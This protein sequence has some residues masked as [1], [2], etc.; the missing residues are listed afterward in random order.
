MGQ[1][2]VYFCASLA[3][4]GGLLFGYDI[5]VISGVLT[6][7][8]FIDIFGVD[9]KI[10]ANVEGGIV[11]SLMA[12]CFVGSLFSGWSCDYFGRKYTIL[13]GSAVFTVGAA[14]QTASHGLGV[15]ITGRVI[16]GL[17]IG[18]LSMAV[19]LYQSEIS[20]PHLRGRLISLQQWAITIGIF[21]AFLLNYGF[22]FTDGEVSWRAP[23]GIQIAPAVVLAFGCMFLSFSPRWL[24]KKGRL[25]DAKQVLAKL[26]ADGNINDELVAAEFNEIYEEV[27]LERAAAASTSWSQVFGPRCRRRIAL[28]ILIQALQQL[29][30]IN[31]IMYYAPKVF[32]SAGLDDQKGPLL[33]QAINGVVNVLSTIPA[34]LFVD[35]WGRRKTLMSGALIMGVAMTIVGILIAVYAQDVNG[36]TVVTNSG[37]TYSVIVFV[38]VF[39]AG[40]AFSWGPI[41]WIYPSEIFP[42]NIRAKGVALATAS[43]WLFNFII[44]QVSPLLME[45]IGFGLY[46]IFAIFCAIMIV[47]IY[48]LFPETKGKT[49]EMMDEV[50]G[51]TTDAAPSSK[52]KEAAA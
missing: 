38:Y 31:S 33:A 11:S 5:G 9:G 22:S 41:A 43:N 8:H 17:A 49:L 16:A 10:S 46:I 21:V 14:L 30:G 40:F 6:Q 13:I 3:A 47:S 45:S 34:V 39:V 19:P 50:F 44:G 15:M 51:A 35:S 24:I 29:T 23:L 12:G 7:P 1:A 42:L 4:I 26:R 48:F 28:G 20:P 2:F 52:A 18:V 36:K 32:A 25:D 27:E 37:A